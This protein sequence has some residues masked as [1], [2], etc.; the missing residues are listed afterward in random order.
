MMVMMT[1]QLCIIITLIVIA[2]LLM[3]TVHYDYKSYPKSRGVRASCEKKSE[4][5]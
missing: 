4:I 1:I 5:I 3:K 2:K